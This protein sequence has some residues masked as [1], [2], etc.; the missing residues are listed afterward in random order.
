[1]FKLSLISLNKIQS[2]NDLEI[3]Y[4]SY[5]INLPEYFSISL[6]MEY[7]CRKEFPD[8][9]QELLSDFHQIQNMIHWI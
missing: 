7:K 2:Y 3:D 4:N 9:D 5:F 8:K 6:L 1:M